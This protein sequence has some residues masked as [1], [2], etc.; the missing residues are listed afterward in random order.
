MFV[1]E[2]PL[3][4]KTLFPVLFA[5][6]IL[7]NFVS[8]PAALASQGSA[9]SQ[10]SSAKNLIKDCYLAVKEAEAEG[11]DIGTLMV[12]LNEAGLLLSEA[13]LAYSVKEYSLADD[14]ARQSRSKLSNLISQAQDLRQTAI[15][16]GTQ[17]FVTLT[18]SLLASIGILSGGI[19]AWV[20]LKRK[21]RLGSNG[22]SA[23]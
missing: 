9:E 20:V 11:A 13:E 3:R 10:I 5:V 6:M 15:N 2:E 23:V 16:A 14:Y 17:E 8:F 22:S 19:A 7:A 21:E 4:L 1:G 12:T 18:L